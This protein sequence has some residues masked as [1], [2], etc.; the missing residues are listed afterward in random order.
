MAML[1]VN[2]FQNDGLQSLEY[3][4]IEFNNVNGLGVG[5]DSELVVAGDQFFLILLS[6]TL[7]ILA[8]MVLKEFIDCTFE[9]E[10]N[11]TSLLKL[12]FKILTL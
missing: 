8:F 5:V 1:K 9:H 2:T 11:I 10:N 7:S 12:M 4:F 6:Q 3:F